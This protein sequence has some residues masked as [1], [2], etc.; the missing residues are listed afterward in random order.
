MELV[1]SCEVDHREP[2]ILDH[3]QAPVDPLT[4]PS[5]ESDLRKDDVNV[6]GSPRDQSDRGKGV[7][8][9]VVCVL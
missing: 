8:D 2:S 1:G 3:V 9:G 6:P 5:G 7:R 4:L